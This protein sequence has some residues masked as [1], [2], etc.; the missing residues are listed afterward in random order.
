MPPNGRIELIEIEYEEMEP[1]L[2]PLIALQA[3]APLLHPELL[4]YRGLPGKLAEPSNLFVHMS[5]GN[6]DI[7][8]GFQQSDRIIEN[9]FTTP[10]VHQAYLEPH[11]CVVLADPSRGAEIW[12]CSKTPF[13]VRD[14]LSESLNVSKDK[15]RL[16]PQ[17]HRWR[18]WRQGRLDGY[19]GLLLFV[20]EER[21]SDKNGHGLQRG[22][23]GRKPTARIDSPREDRR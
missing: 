17:P 7:D 9:R 6:G 4:S 5:W 2:D 11:S 16:S 10:V 21:P 19:S 15:L 14:Q 23:D 8:V 12:S 18:F 22:V 1:L 3:T 13:A 20:L